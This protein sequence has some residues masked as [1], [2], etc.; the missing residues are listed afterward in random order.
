VGRDGN[1]ALSTLTLLFGDN[2]D[3]LVGTSPTNPGFVPV[4][5]V[6]QAVDE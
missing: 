2:P 4:D 6:Q 3:P 1:S 5:D